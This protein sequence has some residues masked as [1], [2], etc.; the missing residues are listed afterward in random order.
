[1]KN[2]LLFLVR[3]WRKSIQE[4]NAAEAK[5]A[6]LGRGCAEVERLHQ[7]QAQNYKRITE[8]LDQFGGQEPQ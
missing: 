7:K 8:Y 6:A 5:V 1:M 3:K 4:Y 2:T